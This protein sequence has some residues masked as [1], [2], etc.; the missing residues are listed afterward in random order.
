MAEWVRS[1]ASPVSTRRR[2]TEQ[3]WR[4]VKELY[5][6][7]SSLVGWVASVPSFG[8]VV[9]LPHTGVPG[10]VLAPGFES[11]VAFRRR[12]EAHAVGEPVSVRVLGFAEGRL[13]VNLE[14]RALGERGQEG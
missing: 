14:L 6:L 9:T 10:V 7:G 12:H 8:L 4:D 13:E 1:G 5:P 3:E 11:P 2:A